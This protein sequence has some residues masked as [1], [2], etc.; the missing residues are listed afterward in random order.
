MLKPFELVRLE[1]SSQGTRCAAFKQLVPVVARMR[2]P[3]CFVRRVHCAGGA[4]GHA[5]ARFAPSDPRL[6]SHLRRA[7]RTPVR[8]RVQLVL[9]A[10][11]S[12][13]LRRAG[14]ALAR[15]GV[16]LVLAAAV[17]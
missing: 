10:A 1:P 17:G 8:L 12:N 6:Y 9:A 16:Q 2:A 3:R 5:H 7:G 13:K 15:L 11:A 14:L 4:F